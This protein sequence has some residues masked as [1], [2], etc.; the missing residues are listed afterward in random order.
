MVVAG[1]VTGGVITGVNAALVIFLASAGCRVAVFINV[2]DDP[3]A[4]VIFLV[5][6]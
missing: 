1:V 3:A 6:C 2:I 5:R 4:V